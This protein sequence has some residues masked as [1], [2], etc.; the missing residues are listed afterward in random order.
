M[1][2]TLLAVL[3]SVLFAVYVDVAQ[4]AKSCEV[5]N[6]MLQKVVDDLKQERQDL[7]SESIENKFVA[8]CKD[9]EVNVESRFVSCTLTCI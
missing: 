6:K 4:A 7:T 8:L 3:V 9:T 5:C 2:G 1:K